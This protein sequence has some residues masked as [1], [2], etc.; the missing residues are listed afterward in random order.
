MP[1][2]PT[3]ASSRR[4]SRASPAKWQCAEPVSRHQ[5]VYGAV[6]GSVAF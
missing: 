3:S 2:A 1:T 6:R 4:I 5:H